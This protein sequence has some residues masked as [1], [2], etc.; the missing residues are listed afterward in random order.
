MMYCW[1]I[2]AKKLIEFYAEVRPMGLLNDLRMFWYFRIRHPW[3]KV[4]K[5]VHVQLGCYFGGAEP[6]IRIGD[7]VGIGFNCFFLSKCRIGNDVLIASNC[8]F[9]N[10]HDH[11]YD[12][13][14]KSVWESGR[15]A[16]GWITI[17]DDVWIGQSVTVLAPLVV[18]RG[19]VI[20]AGSIVVNDVPSYSIV[21]GNPARVLRMRFTTAEIEEHERLRANGR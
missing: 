13:V 18:G 5:Q 11:R 17:E 8:H 14:G 15:G 16:A 19:A 10:R 12:V 2:E 20:A 6:E 4:G 9:V 7:R 3:A 1:E 21:A